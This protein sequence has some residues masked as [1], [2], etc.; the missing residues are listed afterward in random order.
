MVIIQRK[1]NRRYTGY[2]SHPGHQVTWTDAMFV[3]ATISNACCQESLKGQRASSDTSPT[4]HNRLSTTHSTAP[5][6]PLPL[7]HSPHQ[8]RHILLKNDFLSFLLIA[9]RVESQ[10]SPRKT[11]EPNA[12]QKRNKAKGGNTQRSQLQGNARCRVETRAE[13]MNAEG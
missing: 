1:S 5:S 6:S 10:T 3:R 7:T 12:T 2:I 11:K 8:I 4:Y 13:T 9:S